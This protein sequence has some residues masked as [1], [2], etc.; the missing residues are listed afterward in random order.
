MIIIHAAQLDGSLT[1]WGE[2]SDPPPPSERLSDIH[3][4]RCASAL[5]LAEAVDVA[6]EC[7]AGADAGGIIWLPSRVEAD[8]T[9]LIFCAVDDLGALGYSILCRLASVLYGTTFVAV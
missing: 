4:P 8:S 3:H 5:R 1:L 2:D 9:A 7:A 6:T